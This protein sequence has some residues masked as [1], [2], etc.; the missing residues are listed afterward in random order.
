MNPKNDEPQWL[1][2]LPNKLTL[3]RIG[4]VPL[5]MILYP[6][7]IQFFD[8]I[9][10]VIFFFAAATDFFDGYIARKYNS[11][12]QLGKLLDPIADKLLTLA[13]VILLASR[14]IL[15]S[16][17]AILVLA[18][19]FIV[20]GL[21]LIAKEEG[22]SIEV[23]DFGKLKTVVLDLALLFLFIDTQNSHD[24]GIFLSWVA[25]A[26]SYYSAYTY[27]QVFWQKTKSQF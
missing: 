1:T 5:L 19:E 11:I 16:F 14:G 15:P 27:A 24:L 22:F 17:I 9:C 21:R 12:S 13:A 10:A 26:F 6:L 20:S 25:L 4:A 23:S 7:E 18:R 8:I 3:A 2:N